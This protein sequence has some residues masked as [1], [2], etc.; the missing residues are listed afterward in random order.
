MS[1]KFYKINCVEPARKSGWKKKHSKKIREMY[2][3]AAPWLQSSLTSPQT[4]PIFFLY[5]LLNFLPHLFH[6][7]CSFTLQL[8]SAPPPHLCLSGPHT[9]YHHQYIYTF[10][11]T[12]III[13]HN[14]Q[15]KVREEKE[16]VLQKKFNNK[17]KDEKECISLCNFSPTNSNPLLRWF[18]FFTS[19]MVFGLSPSVLILWITKLILV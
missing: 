12:W 7:F 13:P 9:L 4:Q 2:T 5:F 15:Q 6:P 19:S 8:S 11:W 10:S 16:K 1:L 14:I 17:I 18:F 3:W